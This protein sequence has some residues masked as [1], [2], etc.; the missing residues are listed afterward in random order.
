MKSKA[1]L[2]ERKFKTGK[3]KNSSSSR[4]KNK[5]Q[6]VCRAKQK[7]WLPLFGLHTNFAL[8]QATISPGV[9]EFRFHLAPFC[10][11]PHIYLYIYD[12]LGGMGGMGGSGRW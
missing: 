8:A 1:G 12:L 6:S 3:K 5:R 2:Q 7:K 10:N 4:K 11:G 9:M